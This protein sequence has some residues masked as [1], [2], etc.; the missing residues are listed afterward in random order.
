MI[1]RYVNHKERVSEIRTSVACIK[2]EQACTLYSCFYFNLSCS[3]IYICVYP[4]L[5]VGCC[6]RVYL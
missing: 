6:K 4:D 5:D 3:E 1:V 2:L